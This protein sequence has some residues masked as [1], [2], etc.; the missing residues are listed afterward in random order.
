MPAQRLLQVNGDR[1]QIQQV[2]LNLILNGMEAMADA[3]AGQRKILGRTVQLD[4]R[5]AEISISDFGPGIS[6]AD[7]EKVFDPFFTTKT[8]GMG[9]GLSIAR[10]IVETNGGRIWAEPHAAGGAV[11]RF[12]LPLAKRVHEDA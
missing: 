5:F 9:M 4:D 6:S 12:T 2:I 7:L 10:T 11:F 3:P 8:E 1:I